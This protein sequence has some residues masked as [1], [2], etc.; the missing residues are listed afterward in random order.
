MKSSLFH[1]KTHTLGR[2]I[3]KFIGPIHILLAIIMI[4]LKHNLK[5]MTAVDV[6]NNYIDV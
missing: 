2:F 1:M 3:I 5:I 6:K 4:N